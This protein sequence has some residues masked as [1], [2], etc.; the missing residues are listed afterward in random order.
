MVTTRTGRPAPAPTRTQEVYARLR[1]AIVLGELRPNERLVEAE[2]AERLAVSRTPIRE[3]L[4]RLA[5][6]GLIVNRGHGWSVLEHT[7][8]QIREIYDVRAALEGYA[9]RLAALRATEVQVT[10]IEG[11]AARAESAVHLA[12]AQI[13]AANERFHDSVIASAGSGRLALA[14]E[15]TRAYYFNHRIAA[16]YSEAELAQAFGAHRGIAEAV[17]CRDADQAEY[18]ARVHVAEALELVLHKL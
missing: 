10:E 14:V 18:L 4:P 2:L 12:R 16:A 7:A 17:R 6:E 8:D 3:C 15:Q 9:T 5:S 11:L 13:V 1:D